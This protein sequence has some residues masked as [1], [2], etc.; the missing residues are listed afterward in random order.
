M[1]EDFMEGEE[2]GEADLGQPPASVDGT[3]CEAQA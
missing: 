3:G 2:E 1:L